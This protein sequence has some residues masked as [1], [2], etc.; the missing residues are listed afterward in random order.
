MIFYKF[1]IS[2]RH[3]LPSQSSNGHVFDSRWVVI[4]STYSSV[5]ERS[6]AEFFLLYSMGKDFELLRMDLWQI[7]VE[8]W[9]VLE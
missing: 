7:M 4:N 2:K 6:I 1:I 9:S 8:H 3:V 5:A